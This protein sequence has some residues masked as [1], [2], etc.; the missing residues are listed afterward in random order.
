MGYHALWKNTTGGCNTAIGENTLYGQYR[1]GSFNNA[2]GSQAL[3]CNNVG[4][5]NQA[6]GQYSLY[7]NTSG[8]G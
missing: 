6:I 3:Y 2:I 7:H 1:Q 8:D 4:D 5:H